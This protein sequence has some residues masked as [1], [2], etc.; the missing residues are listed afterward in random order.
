MI[1]RSG[2]LLTN[3]KKL[4]RAYSTGMQL[5]FWFKKLAL[6][7]HLHNREQMIVDGAL[8]SNLMLTLMKVTSFVDSEFRGDHIMQE[9]KTWQELQHVA[10]LRGSD[11]YL[12]DSEVPLT[13]RNVHNGATTINILGNTH[14]SLLL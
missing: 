14:N 4:A 2:R 13:H 8:W 5:E 11:D 7:V 6:E 12:N 3:N 1:Q 9:T 10:L